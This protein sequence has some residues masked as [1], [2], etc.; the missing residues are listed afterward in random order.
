MAK[1][2]QV[3]AQTESEQQR[4]AGPQ[5]K[6][7]KST[8]N[9][10]AECKSAYSRAQQRTATAT[11]RHCGGSGS[12]A[13]SFGTLRLSLFGWRSAVRIGGRAPVLRYLSNRLQRVAATRTL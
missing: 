6:Q 9:S 1:R 11:E 7:G 10:G 12:G 5:G 3:L 8:K 4:N 13:A 2:R